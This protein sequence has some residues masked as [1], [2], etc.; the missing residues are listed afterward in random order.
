MDRQRGK[1]NIGAAGRPAECC[2]QRMLTGV[3]VD[4]CTQEHTQVLTVIYSISYYLQ[5]L[6]QFGYIIKGQCPDI[7]HNIDIVSS[8]SSPTCERGRF[9]FHNPLWDWP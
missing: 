4:C 3:Q 2:T 6:S 9:M 7:A 1:K 5:L 8:S